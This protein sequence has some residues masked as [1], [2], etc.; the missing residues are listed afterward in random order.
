MKIFNILFLILAVSC[1]KSQNNVSIDNS[2]NTNT[3]TNPTK[4]NCDNSFQFGKSTLCVPKIK[5]MH[6]II[7]NPQSK[8]YI[9]SKNYPGNTFVA[10]FVNEKIFQNLEKLYEDQFDDFFQIYV[11]NSNDDIDVNNEYLNSIN[12]RA[13]EY[14]NSS[15]WKYLKSKLEDINKNNV[16]EKPIIVENY[17]LTPNSIQN[18]TLVSIK[19]GTNQRN[20]IAVGNMFIVDNRLFY[21]TYYHNFQNYKSIE[22]AKERHDEIMLQVL[23]SN[24]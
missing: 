15:N 9:Q 5:G 14:V 4:K 20:M 11:T 2:L 22:E 17:S 19:S 18:V 12:E 23:K 10:Y 21:A 7:L 8:D 24:E 3:N 13:K 1:S 6:N 16:F